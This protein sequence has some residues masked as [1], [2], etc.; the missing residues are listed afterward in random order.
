MKSPYHK[1]R[2]FVSK[3]E[4]IIINSLYIMTFIRIYLNFMNFKD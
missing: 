4:S 1:Q 3:S 2:L